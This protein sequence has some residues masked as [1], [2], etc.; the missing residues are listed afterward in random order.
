MF[1]IKIINVWLSKSWNKRIHVEIQAIFQY[2]LH[3]PGFHSH[4]V[5]THKQEIE[6]LKRGKS[7]VTGKW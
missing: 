1:Y 2:N 5:I 3:M 6:N 4:N 7:E